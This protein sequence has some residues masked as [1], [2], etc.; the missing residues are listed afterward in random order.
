MVLRPM[1]ATDLDLFL[2]CDG[3]CEQASNPRVITAEPT[4]DGELIITACGTV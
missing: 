4:S 1:G 2:A 3:F